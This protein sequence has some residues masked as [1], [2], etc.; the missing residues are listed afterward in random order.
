VAHR[1]LFK[2]KVGDT[3]TF[4]MKF[5][6]PSCGLEGL[7]G[8]SHKVVET[9]DYGG[10]CY[11]LEGKDSWFRQTCFAGKTENLGW[12][13]KTEAAWN[14]LKCRELTGEDTMYI[15]S[16]CGHSATYTVDGKSA[17]TRF[18]PHCGKYMTNATYIEED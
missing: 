14:K 18:C 10:A 4:K 9:R 15:C 17:D 1:T 13:K 8:T 16:C 11:R 12:D 2:Y 3:I 5:H 6:S 7:E